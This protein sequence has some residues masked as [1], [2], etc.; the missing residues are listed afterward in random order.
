MKLK[1]DDGILSVISQALHTT[2]GRN[3]DVQ[4]LDLRIFGF[5]IQ[6]RHLINAD[7]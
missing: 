1:D 5:G 7:L 6:H 4:V 3:V 2:V